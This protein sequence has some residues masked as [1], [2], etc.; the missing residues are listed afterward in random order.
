ML[1]QLSCCM[2][3]QTEIKLNNREN[4]KGYR[5]DRAAIINGPGG[6]EVLGL[7]KGREKKI[8][9]RKVESGT[10]TSWSHSVSHANRGLEERCVTVNDIK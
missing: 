7:E 10:I 5:R 9:T 8:P 1:I 2:V 3:R 6:Q 4:M